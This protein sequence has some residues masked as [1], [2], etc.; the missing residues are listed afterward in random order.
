MRHTLYFSAFV[1]SVLLAGVTLSSCNKDDVVGGESD[2][3][4]DSPF[5]KFD[6]VK[7]YEWLPAP[8]Q[9]INENTLAGDGAVELATMDEAIAWAQDRINSN[10]YV[11][12]GSFGGYIV[13]GL[14]HSISASG[15]EYDF[16]VA[17]NAFLSNSG[18]SNEPG[19]VWV[20][21]DTNHNGLP[22][23]QWYELEG[24][25]T[26]APETVHGYAVTYYRP[27]APGMDTKWTASDGSTG[28]V[29]YI[30]PFH[31][32]DYYYPAWVK[33]DSYTLTGTL[34]SSKNSQNP[35]TGF[36]NNKAYDWGYAD[37]IGSDNLTPNANSTTAQR[38][39]FKISN[40]IK[41]DGSKA[42]LE[43]VDFVKIQTGVLATSGA[44]GEIS[45]EVL[46]FGEYV[47]EDY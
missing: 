20:M 36:W 34:L 5:E 47:A 12:L 19:I 2:T 31:K 4:S 33:E 41:A 27:E 26:S 45:T 42:N 46:G 25:D 13:V 9:F 43:Y 1:T 39:G 32:Q 14:D 21:Q 38:C 30:A 10:L 3:P 18:G 7:V 37:N 35:E 16:Y 23:D 24:S 11:S 8:G 22:D 40:A 29:K 17:G 44:L 28:V 6:G 15:D